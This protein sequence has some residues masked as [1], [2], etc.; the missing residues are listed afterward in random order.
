MKKMLAA[1]AAALL[2]VAVALAFTA[3]AAGNAGDDDT[4]DPPAPQKTRLQQ[5]YDEVYAQYPAATSCYEIGSDGSYIE[6][7][8]NPFNIDDYY[9]ATY[10]DVLKAFN[11]ELGVPDYVYQLMITTTAMQ[12]R[13]TETVNGLTISWTYHPDNGLA[14]IYRLAE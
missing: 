7:D 13:Q 14:V 4:Q 9:N 1:L 12:G 8:T 11:S 3:C 6:V 2:C 5:A 10:V